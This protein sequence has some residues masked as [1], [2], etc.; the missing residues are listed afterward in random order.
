SAA[1][2]A[3]HLD[4][5]VVLGIFVEVDANIALTLLFLFFVAHEI[6]LRNRRFLDLFFCPPTGWSRPFRPASKAIPTGSALAAEVDTSGAEAQKHLPFQRRAK[7]LL[8]PVNQG[9]PSDPKPRA[10]QTTPAVYGQ[11]LAPPSPC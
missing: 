3:D 7:A 8:H 2:H 9:L 6:T 11:I 10:S 1:A 5:G 4:L